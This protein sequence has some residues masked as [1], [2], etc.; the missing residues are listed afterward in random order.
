MATITT[1][2]VA[3]G[4]KGTTEF[5]ADLGE[6]LLFRTMKDVVVQFQSNRRQGDAHTKNRGEVSGNTA[7]P[8]RQKKTGRARAG[9]KKSPHWR[10]GGNAFG[11]RNNR[12]WTYHLPRKQRNVALRSALA[13]KIRDEE[14]IQISGVNF[15]GPSS[16]AARQTIQGCAPKG[17]VL[18]LLAD[19]NANAWKSFRNFPQVSVRTAADVNAYDLLAHKWTLALEGALDALQG[20][21]AK[22]AKPRQE[23]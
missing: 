15:D 16:K 22:L 1:F 5:G 6:Q 10:G 18:V 13:G 19:N 4:A 9:D 21:L 7:K 2:D 12:Q 20:R 3:K 23:G 11:P 14:V 17:T 8:W